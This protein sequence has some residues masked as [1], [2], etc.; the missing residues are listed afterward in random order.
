MV[1]KEF[2]EETD[3]VV[4]LDLEGLG[5]GLTE[6]EADLVLLQVGNVRMLLVQDP[7]SRLLCR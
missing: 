2:G 6:D 1:E 4:R 3:R 5:Q 7:P